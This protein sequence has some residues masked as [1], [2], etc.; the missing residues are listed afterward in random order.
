MMRRCNQSIRLLTLL[1]ISFTGLQVNGAE[2]TS[3]DQISFHKQIRPLFQAKCQG[4]H[5]P[6]KA[7]GKYVMT[8]F[9][10]LLKGGSSGD[11]AIV[12]GKPDKSYLVEL[13]TPIDGQAEMPSK[14]DPLHATEIALIRKW[15]EQGARDDTPENARERI[16][17][18]H[19]PVY[20]HPPLVTSMDFSPKGDL[21]A[22]SGFHEV[23][24]I[25]TADWSRVGRLIGVSQR[26]ESVAFSPDGSKLAVAGGLPG[27]MGEIQV[28]NVAKQSLDLSAAG[29]L[30]HGV[31]RELVARRNEACISVVQTT[32]RARS[33]PRPASKSSTWQLTTTGCK[34]TV[35]SAWTTSPSSP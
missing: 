29:E 15:I 17:K 19:P 28:W 25:K 7:K 4:C 21:L 35:F 6:A 34:D 24:L 5:Q 32:P 23:L 30:R 33:M 11:L 2:P 9:E 3:R 1:A 22:V 18:D 20:T 31:R 12:P 13:I 14:G 26:I 8:G 16:D 10:Q 27:R